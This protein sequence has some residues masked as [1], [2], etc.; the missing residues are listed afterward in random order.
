MF[1]ISLVAV[2]IAA[3]YAELYLSGSTTLPEACW[4]EVYKD[5]RGFGVRVFNVSYQNGYECIRLK[6]LCDYRN[7]KLPVCVD[8][9]QTNCY[10]PLSDINCTWF[11]AHYEMGQ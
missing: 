4:L 2:A 11:D 6:N 7:P 3:L 10:N 1:F 9:D 8:A 5:G